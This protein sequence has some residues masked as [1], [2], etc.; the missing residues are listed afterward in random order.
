MKPAKRGFPQKLM[1]LMQ[2]FNEYLFSLFVCFPRF[3]AVAI[4]RCSNDNVSPDCLRNTTLL[5]IKILKQYLILFLYMRD[6]F[7]HVR[8]NLSAHVILLF[9][10]SSFTPRDH[11]FLL[12]QSTSRGRTAVMNLQ[13][14]IPGMHCGERERESACDRERERERARVQERERARGLGSE[15]EEHRVDLSAE[16]EEK[17]AA[18]SLKEKKKKICYPNLVITD[19]RSGKKCSPSTEARVAV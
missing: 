18:A 15:A 12:S 10:F 9:L 16:E 2:T 1:Q 8:Y 14:K 5:I 17:E 19:T 3:G 4:M 13:P 7:K 6:F 11:N